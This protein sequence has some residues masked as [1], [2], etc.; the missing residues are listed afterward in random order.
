M[1]YEAAYDEISRGGYRAS[2][3]TPVPPAVSPRLFASKARE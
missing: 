1:T 2:A 3:D